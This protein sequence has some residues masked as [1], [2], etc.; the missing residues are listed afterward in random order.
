F[1]GTV[2]INNPDVNTTA[3]LVQLPENITDQSN[4]INVGCAATLGNSFTITGRGGLPQSPTTPLRGRAIWRDVRNAS[5]ATPRAN[6][7]S[8]KSEPNVQLVEATGWIVNDLGQLE[9]VANLPSQTGVS[10]APNCDDL[11]RLRSQM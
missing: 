8:K 7:S 3:G 4:Q 2:T 1:S 11:P 5:S 9:L 6:I 10:S